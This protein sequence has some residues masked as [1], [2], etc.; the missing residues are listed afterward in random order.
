M[1]RVTSIGCVV[2][3]RPSGRLSLHLSAFHCLCSQSYFALQS[4]DSSGGVTS[5]VVIFTVKIWDKIAA[6]WCVCLFV[7]VFRLC[8]E[9]DHRKTT[10]VSI[11]KSKETDF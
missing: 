6:A 4:A 2:D 7:G 5:D 10:M 9:D 3:G 11:R 1:L 8:D